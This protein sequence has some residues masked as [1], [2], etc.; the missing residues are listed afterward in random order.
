MKLGAIDRYETHVPDAVGDADLVVLATP[1][2]TY[3][4]HLKD[5][6]H[7]FIGQGAIV[8]DVGSVKGRLVEEA[9]GLTPIRGAFCWRSPHCGS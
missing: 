3:G 7:A 2:E 8:S 5:W 1:V 4:T 9:E 6:G